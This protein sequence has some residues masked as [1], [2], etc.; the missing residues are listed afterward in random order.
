MADTHDTIEGLLAEF[1]GSGY[2]DGSGD[3]DDDDDDE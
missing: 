2:G 3:D 1:R